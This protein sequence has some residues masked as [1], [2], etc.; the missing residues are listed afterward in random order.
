MKRQTYL[1][2]FA[3][4]VLALV[5]GST[6]LHQKRR[7]S[8]SSSPATISSNAIVAQVRS[9]NKGLATQVS[10]SRVTYVLSQEDRVSVPK[11]DAVQV[12]A[13]LR[14]AAD[15]GDAKAAL[16]IY[17]KL[18]ECN[19]AMR[20]KVSDSELDA[21]RKAGADKGLMQ[22]MLDR[23]EACDGVQPLLVDRGRWLEN[24]ADAGLLEAQL[25]Y[26]DSPGSIIGGAS[27]MLSDPQKVERY[28]AKAVA[29]LSNRA[30][31]GNIDAIMRL[32]NAYDKGILLKQDHVKG[33]AYF[34]V[35]DLAQ[36]GLLPDALLSSKRNRVEP[37]RRGEAEQT[38]R[39]FYKQCC[40]V[41]N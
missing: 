1:V 4:L 19:N 22:G 25:L 24:A 12:V 16:A 40:M 31:D 15:A 10:K 7:V 26:A 6:F 35:I 2:L 13:T 29:Y 28:K 32:G 23:L 17:L 37:S 34:K 33:Y 39:Q 27:A 5:G 3:L 30:A 38:A 21:Y 8:V 9:P 14:R 18:N 41:N 36:P 11:G 20:D